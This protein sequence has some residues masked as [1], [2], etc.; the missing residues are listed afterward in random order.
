[1][2]RHRR[3][4]T[5]R[6]RCGELLF[7]RGQ[8]I[9][10]ACDTKATPEAPLAPSVYDGLTAA[11]IMRRAGY[12]DGRAGRPMSEQHFANA[13]YCVGYSEGRRVREGQQPRVAV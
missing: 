2:S 6:C 11:Q 13:D 9:C 4:P 12:L 8:L 7:Q 3:Y 10:A 5:G 1:M